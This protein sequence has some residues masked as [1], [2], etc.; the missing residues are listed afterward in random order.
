MKYS[1]NWL[2]EISGSEKTP[3]EIKDLLMLHAF[4]VEGIEKVENKLDGVVVGEILEIEKH[5]DADK[6]Q[7]TRTLIK[8]GGLPAGRQVL[9][10]VCG[11]KNI[12]VGDK[13]PVA[14]VGTTLP[15]DFKIKEAEIRGVKSFGMLCAEDELGL[16]TS[17]EGIL[18]LDRN[19]EIGTPIKDVL[20]LDDAMI[21]IDILA[22]RAHDAL[23]HV[24]MGREIAILEGREIDYDYDGLKLSKIKSKKLSVQIADKNIC[25]RYVGAV[26][27]GVEVSDSPQWI[28]NRLQLCGIRPINNIVD[29]TNL[30]MLEIGQPLHAFDFDKIKSEIPN[31]K[32]QIPSKS[33][34]SNI[35]NQTVKII[36]RNARE[37]EEITILDGS[38]KKLS[39]EDIVIANNEE[40]IALAGIMGGL[41]TGVTKE[42]K[43]IVLESANFAPATIRRT[44][45]RLGIS[46]DAALR[47]EKEIDPNIAEKAMVRVIEILEHVAGG[48]LEGGL[49]EYPEK[50]KTWSIKLDLA[51][52]DKLLG[53]AIPSKESKKILS[54]LGI[55]V[56]G[57]GNVINCEIPTYRLDIATQ[58]DL[59]EEIGRIYGYEKISTVAPL[60]SVQPAPV[61]LQRAF[62]RQTKN[63]LTGLGFDE[64][65]NYSFYSEKDAKAAQL[66]LLK[67]LELEAPMSLDQALMRVSLVPNLLK[68]VRENLKNFKQFN[69]FEIGKVY[70]V[71]GE[72]LP[73]EKN[74]L[75][76][77]IVMEKKSAKEE[78]MDKRHGSVFFEA[79]SY[80]DHLLEQI[81]ITDHYYDT[82]EGSSIETPSSLWHQSRTAEIKIQG[83]GESIGFLGEI[84]PFVLEEFDISSRVA[85]F[86]FDM[87]KLGAVSEAER[88]FSPIRKHPVV[89]RDISLLVES[90]V[91]V[92]E[93]L[94]VIQK[95]GGDFVLDVDMF[96]VIDFA[97]DT[98][99]LAFHVILGAD[100]RTLTG[101]EIDDV[102]ISITNE[103]EKNLKVKMRR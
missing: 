70:W 30:V 88:E 3:E 54:L 91:L 23:S 37:G 65:Y 41:E 8:E 75:T 46:S 63:V 32:L 87:E 55:K 38:S 13:V 99:S 25:C 74:L 43:N 42:T 80:V 31:D 18:L 69:I 11:A 14:T 40:A 72:A 10:I 4:E 79:K 77:A 101:K 64:V 50:K 34:N 84:N 26:L 15:G 98:S 92:D 45:M 66:G 57:M 90:S 27:E 49:D 89:T 36:V 103:L 83:S 96:D 94:M 71:N 93:I 35:N 58:E 60:V 28:K 33:Q 73:E 86:E 59:I 78:K 24:G 61:N 17:H 12:S 100:E 22:N 62:V 53:I 19:L 20:D 47:F 39:S 29:A 102:M 56:S 85:M 52:A 51:Y 6:L 2:S 21:E 48:A 97:D 81:G 82:F 9:Q 1:Y 76:G 16:G 5:P 7:V 95:A 67:H 44:R 68:N